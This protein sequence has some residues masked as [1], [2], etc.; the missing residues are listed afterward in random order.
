MRDEVD[1][2]ATD[3]LNRFVDVK[4]FLFFLLYLPLWCWG[5][6][7]M[8]TNVKHWYD[9]QAEVRFDLKP[10]KSKTKTEV[11]YK[12]SLQVTEYALSA[13]SISWEKRDF[14]SQR[15]GEEITTGIEELPDSVWRQGKITV[16]FSDKPWLLLAKVK[17]NTTGDR[18]IYST[19]IEAKY[20]VNGFLESGSNVV[21]HSYVE[22]NKSYSIHGQEKGTPLYVFYYKQDFMAGFPP[23]AEKEV[24]VDRF[25]FADSS[26]SVISG[27]ELFVKKE[28]LYLVQQDTNSAE[29][30]A[31]RGEDNAYPKFTKM[32]DLTE[33]M[34]FISTPEEY[35]ALLAANNEKP[36]FDKVIL[37]ITKDRDRAKN[38][39]RS[40]FQRV[41]LANQ[42]FTSYKE[43]WKTDRGMIYLIFGVPNEVS[44]NDH[45]EIWYYKSFDAHFTFIKSG[46]VYDPNY[47]VLLR[48]KRFAE[49]WYNTIDLWRKSRF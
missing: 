45:N 27:D 19:V 38:F 33:P 24:K 3:V 5:Q 8:N 47:Y 26:F 16:S 1:M 29:G 35:N 31:F 22:T 10:V 20:P 28:G 46:S 7:V 15:N 9:P 42:Y 32:T 43:G 41:E 25:M 21:F 2:Q 44:R 36:K 11:Y 12:L 49:R 37:D 4:C 30:F 18:W 23:F 13:Y 39:M 17:N 34:I 14:Y 40:Y 6:S 48:N